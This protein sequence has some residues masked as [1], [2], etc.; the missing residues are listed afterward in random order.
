MDVINA[1]RAALFISERFASNFGIPYD[2]LIGLLLFI[3]PI[4][5]VARDVKK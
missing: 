3:K 1:V 2:S 4:D 5:D